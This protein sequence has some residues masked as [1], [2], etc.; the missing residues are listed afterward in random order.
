MGRYAKRAS[1]TAEDQ[2]G[3]CSA[4]STS[5]LPS[6]RGG[7]GRRSAAAGAPA[8]RGRPGRAGRAAR[9]RARSGSASPRPSSLPSASGPSRAAITARWHPAPGPRRRAPAG[10]TSRRPA[11]LGAPGRARS[12]RA[13]PP[14]GLRWW[15]LDVRITPERR[16]QRPARWRLRSPRKPK[17][18][19][20]CGRFRNGP[21]RTGRGTCHERASQ[22]GRREAPIRC[23]FART[24]VP[25]AGGAQPSNHKPR[26]QRALPVRL[27]GR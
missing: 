27:R 22:F 4:A 26:G 12:S 15:E 9:G 6:I 16:G 7:R 1:E 8:V 20:S 2:R 19:A 25:G 13:P 18:P 10:A 21:I 3:G 5:A 23:G 11:R 24:Y 14:T 17:P